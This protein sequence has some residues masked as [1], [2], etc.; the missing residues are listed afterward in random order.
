[1]MYFWNPV[2]QNNTLEAADKTQTQC[3]SVKN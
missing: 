1:M 2:N 3:D